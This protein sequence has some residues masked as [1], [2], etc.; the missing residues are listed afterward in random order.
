MSPD[1]TAAREVGAQG[2]W[3]AVLDA[4]GVQF[5]ALDIHSD[6]DLLQR[7]RS[8]PGWIVDFKDEEAVLFVREEHLGT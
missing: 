4:Y 7:F 3:P 5:L 1:H 6:S 2:G 8:H